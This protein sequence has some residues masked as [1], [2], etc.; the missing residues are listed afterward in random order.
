MLKGWF[1]EAFRANDPAFAGY[2]TMLTRTPR[3]GYLATVAA[4]RDADFT[5]LA[6]DI[7]V[8]TLC[9]GGEVDIPTP[10]KLVQE[11]AKL[12][13]GARYE[14]IRD[15]GHIPMVEQPEVV[16]A[17]IRAFADLAGVLDPCRQTALTASR[18]AW[19]R[20]APCSAT[21]TSTA[22]RG[23]QERLRRPVP[24]PHHR[25]RLG[26]R[27]VAARLD[28]SA[29][30]RSSPSRCSPRSAT[31]RRWRCTSAPPPAPARRRS[32]IREALLHVAIYAG[33]PTANHA[34]K[35]AKQAL[36]DVAAGKD[37]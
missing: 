5:A 35:I 23:R 18:T 3:A 6:P 22:C 36:A 20:A 2:R 7:A 26:P 28:A 30:A 9:L 37:D 19:R 24:G 29:S 14:L 21:S 16:A 27:L 13:P 1:T 31:T 4:I 25:S 33:V 12:I 32:D 15:A 8:P 11:L 34:I 10:P 17:M